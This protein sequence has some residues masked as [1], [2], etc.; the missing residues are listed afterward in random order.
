MQRLLLG[1]MALLMLTPVLTCAMP[2]CPVKATQAAAVS[3][4]IDES[5]L[6]PCHRQALKKGLETPTKEGVMLALDCMGID[7][8]NSGVTTDMPYPDIAADMIHY[9]WVDVAAG[10]GVMPESVRTIRGPPDDMVRVEYAPPLI[11]TTQRF[12]I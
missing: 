10:Y 9:I 3:A 12:R 11:L 6:P 1:F 8:F 7:L 4:S 2:F 5:N